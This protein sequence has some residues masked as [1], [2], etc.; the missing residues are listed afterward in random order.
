MQNAGHDRARRP[1][2]CD[3]CVVGAGI[4]GLATARELTARQPGASVA[5]LERERAIARPPDRALQRR[6][7]RRHLLRAGLAEGAALRRGRARALRVLRRARRSARERSGKLIVAATRARSCRAST[8][9]S[10]AA[11]PTGCRA[12]ERLGA[13]ELRRDRAARARRRRPALARHRGR[14]LHRGRRAHTPPTLAAAGGRDRH[15]LRGPRH[16]EPAG[17]AVEVAHGRARPR[18][19]FVVACAGAWADRLAVAA[20]A[21]AE[22]R[23]VPFRGGYLRLRPERR[24]LVRSNIYPVPDPDLPFLGAHLTRDARRRGPARARRRCMV[25][26]RDAYRLARVVRP[27]TSPR[28]SPGPGPG[29]MMRAPLAHRPRRDRATRSAARSS[30]PRRGATSRS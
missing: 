15:R 16:C 27:A 5:V 18:A 10:G 1:E 22:P 14:R 4:V 6:H 24:E 17:G 7:P 29:G 26:A 23:I 28:P 13:G 30:S 2:R 11:S 19:G 21:P 8:S 3:V 12:C 20:G 25:G 9:S